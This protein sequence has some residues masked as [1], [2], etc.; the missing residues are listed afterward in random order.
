MPSCPLLTSWSGLM[1]TRMLFLLLVGF[2]L[3]LLLL[4]AAPRAVAGPS[5]PSAAGLAIP[6][7]GGR[8]AG[9]GN[10]DKR[11]KENQTREEGRRE[12]GAFES[13]GPRA[14][15]FAVFRC[16][17]SVCS[18]CLPTVPFWSRALT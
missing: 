14:S 7:L 3:L 11:K 18:V 6:R 10:K 9:N 17:G 8:R 2:L 5:Q 13:E 12:K 16:G 15:P 4:C 1:T